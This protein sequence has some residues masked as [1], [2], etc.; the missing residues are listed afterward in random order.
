MLST[1]YS[2]ATAKTCATTVKG[3]DSGTAPE[4][5]KTTVRF[6]TER[7]AL[8]FSTNANLV[9]D[10]SFLSKTQDL[11]RGFINLRP[12]KTSSPGLNQQ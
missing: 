5:R 6:V 4:E 9:K 1:N 10:R 11:K 3:K 12:E 2:A 7:A 8:N